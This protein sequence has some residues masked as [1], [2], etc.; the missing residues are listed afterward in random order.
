MEPPLRAGAATRNTI[1]AEILAAL[2]PN[3]IVINAAR[4]SVIDEQVPLF[5]WSASRCNYTLLLLL[6][7]RASIESRS[8][9]NTLTID[10]RMRFEPKRACH[11][12][13]IDA[14]TFP[15]CDLVA[16]AMQFSMVS[17]AQRDNEFVARPAQ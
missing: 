5:V 10:Q 12:E 9:R 17:S 7:H 1:D 3:G 14:I 16:P 2:G 8:C 11:S 6:I 4:G 15:P 13:C